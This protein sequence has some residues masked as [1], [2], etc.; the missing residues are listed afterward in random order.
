MPSRRRS[1]TLDYLGREKQQGRGSMSASRAIY[2]ACASVP[3]RRC[4]SVQQAQRRQKLSPRFEQSRHRSYSSAKRPEKGIL[5]EEA[6][7]AAS[8]S[9]TSTIS[10]SGSTIPIPKSIA[11]YL[12]EYVIGQDKAKRALAVGVFNHYLRAASN[13]LDEDQLQQQRPFPFMN[14]K[15]K[16]IKNKV[17][18][19]KSSEVED[20]ILSDFV[21]QSKGSKRW[22]DG[23]SSAANSGEC[24]FNEQME[25]AL[26]DLTQRFH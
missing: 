17:G 11:A 16:P 18:K 6:A 12:D 3:C 15:T 25:K 20:S 13:R 7:T 9:S 4:L 19:P 23:D 21:G 14:K 26:T 2:M 22:A 24:S 10:L 1:S 8:S 5:G